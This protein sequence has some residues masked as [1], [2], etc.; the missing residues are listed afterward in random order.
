VAFSPDG[1]RIATGSGDKT[2]RVL[3]IATGKEIARRTFESVVR[4]VT[5]SPDGLRIAAAALKTS[6]FEAAT[7]KEIWQNYPDDGNV[8]SL[9][10]SPDGRWIGASTTGMMALILD[11]DTGKDVSHSRHDG[12]IAGLDS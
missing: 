6:V 7:G 3:E 10:F 1:R 9:S 8:T 12:V 5:F 2:A 11:A 4:R